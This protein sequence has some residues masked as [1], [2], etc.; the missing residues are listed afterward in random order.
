SR[1][2]FRWAVLVVGLTLLLWSGVALTAELI[3]F[4][5]QTQ[6][7][8]GDYTA[9]VASFERAFRLNP[10]QAVFPVQI[11]KLQEAMAARGDREPLQ[12]ALQA[13]QRAITLQPTEPVNYLALSRLYEQ[14]GQLQNALQAAQDAVRWYPTYPRGLAQVGRLQDKLGQHAAALA[15][16]ARLVEVYR[17]P[18][19]QV[20]AVDSLIETAY[21]HAWIALGDVDRG[22]KR[23]TEAL[24]QYRLATDLL[25]RA[26]GPERALS[27]QMQAAGEANWGHV[28][29]NT[30]LANQVL[31]RLQKSPLPVSGK[32][33]VSLHEALGDAE[34]AARLLRYLTGLKGSSPETALT[35]AWAAMELAKS[36]PKDRQEE[37][38]SAAKNGLLQAERALRLGVDT[39]LTGWVPQDT[40]DLK[41]LAQWAQT[42]SR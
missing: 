18:V 2:V 41:Q 29:E 22:G 21:V 39:Q 10:G 9:A 34:E 20:Q 8:A 15:A 3:G 14:G 7:A 32:L 28:E 37:V 31:L 36:L 19:G 35:R 23:E 33:M 26:L 11:S 42:L 4:Q 16:F 25:I 40:A 17:S 30:E 38:G 1:P 6:V 13:R 27:Q 12:L 24:A 5:A